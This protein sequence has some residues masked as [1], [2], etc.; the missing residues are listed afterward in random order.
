MQMALLQS[1]LL[2]LLDSFLQP[3]PND[4]LGLMQILGDILH[5]LGDRGVG[6]VILKI[7]QHLRLFFEDVSRLER[8][9][10][11]AKGGT[12]MRGTGLTRSRQ[13]A[14]AVSFGPPIREA[15]AAV[16]GA[17]GLCGP[18]DC[19]PGEGGLRE[20]RFPFAPGDPGAALPSGF[21]PPRADEKNRWFERRAR[22]APGVSRAGAGRGDSVLGGACAPG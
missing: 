2:E 12:G 9:E 21:P 10:E 14:C 7:A 1:R 6:A 17:G 5:R 11:G 22:A 13:G 20:D 16:R 3:E 19:P 18:A 8:K 4:P 15:P